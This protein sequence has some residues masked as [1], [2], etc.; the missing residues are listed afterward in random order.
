MSSIIARLVRESP[1]S[2]PVLSAV[3]ASSVNQALKAFAV[4]RNYVSQD[5][6][7][8]TAV[9]CKTPQED[10]RDVILIKLEVTKEGAEKD[11]G[12]AITMKAS[13]KSRPHALAGAIA[14]NI[15]DNKIPAVT[16]IGKGA[17][18]RVACAAALAITYLEKENVSARVYT[19]FIEVDFDNGTKA[20]AL[21]VNF[22]LTA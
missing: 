17:V 8:L 5:N 10:V 3:G 7:N 18:F 11:L 21:Q 6:I 4:A 1:D 14:G 12:G 2:P 19:K 20:S 16:A 13:A 15:R 9:I 22:L